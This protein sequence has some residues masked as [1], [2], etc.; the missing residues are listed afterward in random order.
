MT[1][2]LRNSGWEL[3][4]DYLPWIWGQINY[5]DIERSRWHDVLRTYHQARHQVVSTSVL[6]RI[7]QTG[8][9]EYDFG[10]ARPQN[11]L[12]AFLAE[13]KEVGLKVVLWVGPRDCPGVA[14]AGYPNE[15]LTDESALARDAKGNFI[16]SARCFGGEIFTLPCLVSDRLTQTLQPFAEMLNQITAPWIHPDGPVIG[17]GLTQAPG[18]S[19]GLSAFA[20]DYN[21]DAVAFYHAFLKKKYSK[22]GNLNA[23]YGTDFSSFSAIHPPQFVENPGLYPE[24]RLLD[25]A[26][27]RE[28]YFVHAAERLHALF[29]KMTLDRIPIYIATIPTTKR[30]ANLNEL[31]RSR[32]FSYAMPEPLH[33][34][35]GTY[36]DIVHQTRFLTAWNTRLDTQTEYNPEAQFALLQGM[37]M[38]VRGW[39]AL[40]PAGA[41]VIS[42]FISNRQGTSVRPRSSF[43]ESLQELAGP[44]G[45]LAS[46]IYGGVFLLTMPDL[47]RAQ[48]LQIPT[49][50]RLDLLDIYPSSDESPALDAITQAYCQRSQQLE[51]FLVKNQ[52]PFLKVGGDAPLE[53]LSRAPMLLVPGISSMP[54][55]IQQLLA[56]LHSKG[57]TIAIV[58]DL[59]ESSQTAK[60]P[61]LRELV[62]VKSRKKSKGKSKAKSDVIGRLYHL[63]QFA[64]DKLIRFLKQA[65]VQR[66]LT[67]DHQDVQM[68]FHKFRNR[69]FV[70][71]VNST[72]E[73]IKTTVRR[74]GKFVL[75]D[76]WRE[77]KYWGGNNEIKIVLPAR[78]VKFWELIPC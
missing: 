32:C 66:P 78:Q 15:L 21:T 8:P 49:P 40:S 77:N 53:R 51:E 10:K 64:E 60:Y 76:F 70:A 17:I 36:L 3:G 28:D 50:Q 6:P 22:I 59:P 12:V 62:G 54:E 19:S 58:G 67:I 65:G 41:G 57:A 44:E 14:A 24:T 20:A 52:F 18:W 5:W 30:P 33:R 43:W 27:F 31:E 63:P 9:G 4:G 34:D 1:V 2:K 55:S 25:W 56:Q 16:L 29:S 39:D 48:Y 73:T 38:G 26:R 37:A 68:F 47:E 23:A 46:Q 61:S 45:F 69:I 74:E 7:H 42:G 75:K 72:G 11:D 35:A 13:A 71:A